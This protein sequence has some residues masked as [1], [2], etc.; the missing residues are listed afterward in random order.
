MRWFDVFLGCSDLTEEDRSYQREFFYRQHVWMIFLKKWVNTFFYVQFFTFNFLRAIVYVQFFTFNF[1]F[2]SGF[3]F[4]TLEHEEE[5]WNYYFL[6]LTRFHLLLFLLQQQSFHF[7]F[8][9]FSFINLIVS[10][11][12]SNPHPF[13]RRE[14]THL[15]SIWGS[16]YSEVSI[17]SGVVGGRPDEITIVSPWKIV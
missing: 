1:D 6:N 15:V 10:F 17:S 3:Y 14:R 12:C 13:F 9:W 2:L 11:Y 5:D 16:I 4:M 7:F 8:N